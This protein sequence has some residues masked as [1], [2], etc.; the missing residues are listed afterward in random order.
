MLFGEHAVL[1]GKPCIVTA[2]SKR[3]KV[4]ARYLEEPVFRLDAPQVNVSN[5]QKAIIDLG[6]GNVPSGVR[7]V[8]AAV[9]NFW[10]RYNPS[11]GVYIRTESEFSSHYGFG[12]SSTTAVGAIYALAELYQISLT[13]REIFDICYKIVLR[14]QQVGSGFDVAASLYGGTLYFIKGGKEIIPLSVYHIPLTVGYS[15]TKADTVD[16][17]EKVA[18]KRQL[19]PDKTNKIFDNIGKIVLEAKDSILDSNWERVGKLMDGNQRNLRQLEVSSDKLEY[20]IKTTKQAGAY[21]AKLS[22]AGGG[23]CMIAV[24]SPDK[25]KEV[26][27]AIEK[28]GGEV[29]DIQTNAEGV[30]SEIKN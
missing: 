19:F 7:F 27:I 17:I 16:M 11:G 3:M 28:A 23:D 20:L 18:K 15:G 8:E 30:R 5:Y 4:E 22:G 25:Q 6:L 26:R 29:I 13:T 2:I 21:G 14:I 10:Q 12:S 1:Y 24:S 9:K